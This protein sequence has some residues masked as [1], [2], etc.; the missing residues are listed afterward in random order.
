MINENKEIF[1]EQKNTNSK[2]GMFLFMFFVNSNKSTKI[3]S[4]YF[5]Y[6]IECNFYLLSLKSIRLLKFLEF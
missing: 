6:K 3:K 4:Y 2:V 1:N 5:P